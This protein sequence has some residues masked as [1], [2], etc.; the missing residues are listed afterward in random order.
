MRVVRLRAG[1]REKERWKEGEGKLVTSDQ[2]KTSILGSY[3]VE[4][5]NMS[6]FRG[7]LFDPY[8]WYI[9]YI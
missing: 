8:I 5:I 1:E 3:L 6:V 4:N 2:C 7:I 9:W